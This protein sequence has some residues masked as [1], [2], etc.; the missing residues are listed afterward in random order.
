MTLNLK[1]KG[2]DHRK[3]YSPVITRNKWNKQVRVSSIKHLCGKVLMTFNL[4]ECLNFLTRASI[5]SCPPWKVYE[6]KMADPTEA[7]HLTL[8][9]T[10]STSSGSKIDGWSRLDNAVGYFRGF[11]LFIY[12]WR[13]LVSRNKYLPPYKHPK[14]LHQIKR[15]WKILFRFKCLCHFRVINNKKCHIIRITW[16]WCG[17]NF[18]KMF[19]MSIELKECYIQLFITVFMWSCLFCSVN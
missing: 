16:G 6:F 5:S 18:S 8:S 3:R 10:F 15:Q 9:F 7:G 17:T 4:A 13:H 1:I 11:W 2:S 19:S 12:N 14:Q